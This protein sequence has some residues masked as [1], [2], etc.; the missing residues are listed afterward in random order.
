M[1]GNAFSRRP[2]GRQSA[3]VAVVLVVVGALTASVALQANPSVVP[4]PSPSS[5]PSAVASEPPAAEWAALDLPPLS[6]PAT[7]E[8]SERDD[9]GIPLTPRSRSRASPT[10]PP[11]PWPTA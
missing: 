2:T 11:P 7:L 4:S 10:N 9:A 8:P 6:V 3:V 5:A 1:V